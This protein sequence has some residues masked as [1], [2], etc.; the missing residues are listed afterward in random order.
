MGLDRAGY[1]QAFDRVNVLYDF[2]GQVG[3]EDSFPMGK[4]KAVARSMTPLFAGRVVVLIGR[5]VATAFGYG[6][7]P[8]FTWTTVSLGPGQ[9]PFE[10]AVLPHPSGRCRVYNSPASRDEARAFLR[11]LV[12]QKVEGGSCLL[13]EGQAERSYAGH[14]RVV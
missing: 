12:E 7:L 13:R 1:L 6:T 5:N 4:A 10:L 8:W 3:R 9:E 14:L 2:P 11:E